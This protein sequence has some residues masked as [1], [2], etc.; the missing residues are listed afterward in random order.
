VYTRFTC[1]IGVLVLHSM[2]LGSLFVYVLL[3]V[4]V[5]LQRL[6]VCIFISGFCCD[7]IIMFSFLVAAIHHSWSIAFVECKSSYFVCEWRRSFMST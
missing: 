4:R 7:S 6:V 3:C 5:P 2:R 1:I